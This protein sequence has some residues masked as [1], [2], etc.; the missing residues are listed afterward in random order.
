MSRKRTPCSLNSEPSSSLRTYPRSSFRKWPR[1]CFSCR[2]LTTKKVPPFQHYCL[3]FHSSNNAKHW[4]YCEGAEW[5]CCMVL[6]NNSD[7]LGAR[8]EGATLN[9]GVPRW[10]R[11]SWTTRTTAHQRRPSCWRPT[12]SMPSTASTTRM[13][14]SQGT[15]P[16][17][18]CCLRGASNTLTFCP[19]H[20]L[21]I[22]YPRKYF[23]AAVVEVVSF[24]FLAQSPGT[25]QADQ[26]AVG[27]PHTD[28]A[29][30]AQRHAQVWEHLWGLTGP[31]SLRVSAHSLK[32]GMCLISAG[33]KNLNYSDLT[34]IQYQR[35]N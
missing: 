18:D 25:A 16:A 12:P 24:A 1:G 26:G 27:G 15:S 31:N 22:T 30:R 21:H 9:S 6:S 11:P 34:K 20:M 17:T 10:R 23:G 32:L 7:K 19:P 13:P 8:V 5:F 28:V 2:W 4:C 33:K 29:W 14:T 3:C 35:F